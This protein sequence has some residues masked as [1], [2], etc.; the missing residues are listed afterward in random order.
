[1]IEPVYDLLQVHLQ[2]DLDL[3]QCIQAHAFK[4]QA[5]THL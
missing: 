1:M 2:Q 4:A 5:Q 3:G